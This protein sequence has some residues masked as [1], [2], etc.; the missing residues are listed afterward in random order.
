[1][2][3][4]GATIHIAILS[5]F[6]EIANLEP[7]YA[8][9]LGF[10]ASLA[11]SYWLNALWSFSTVKQQHR[12]ASVRYVIVS[13]MGL[14][15]NTLLMFL[16]INVFGLWYLTGQAIAAVLVPLHNFLLNF[17]WTFEQ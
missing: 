3:G 11:C 1:M 12:K 6:V 5:A 16:L 4:L 10:L 2:G 9:V 13:V 15:L 14:C 7:I 17:Y 8:S